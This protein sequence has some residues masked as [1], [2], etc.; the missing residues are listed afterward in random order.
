V[1]LWVIAKYVVIT[2]VL[3]EVKVLEKVALQ[4][5]ASYGF[6][7]AVASDAKVIQVQKLS[8]GLED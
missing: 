4:I 8:Q 1:H 3:M 2:S 7:Y 5:Q 6:V